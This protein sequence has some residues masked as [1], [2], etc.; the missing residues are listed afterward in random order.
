MGKHNRQPLNMLWCQE[1]VKIGPDITFTVWSKTRNRLVLPTLI[2]HGD[3]FLQC[4][5]LALYVA[6]TQLHFEDAEQ[7][8]HFFHM[9]SVWGAIF[10]KY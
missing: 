4:A 3:P 10:T 9:H 5:A 8:L 7:S 2:T 6:L 1:N